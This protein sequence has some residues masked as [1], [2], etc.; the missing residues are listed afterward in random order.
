MKAGFIFF[1][2]MLIMLVPSQ[3]QNITAAKPAYLEVFAQRAD[4]TDVLMTSEQLSVN[5]DNLVMK[6]DLELHTCRTDDMLLRNLL[7]S[8]MNDRL[9]F[10]AVIP[11]GKFAFSSTDNERFSVETDLLYGERQSHILLEF[12]VSNQKTSSAN[13]FMISV[14]GSVLLRED[15]G[16]EKNT[17]INN[18]LSFRF[19][20]NVSKRTF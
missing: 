19:T 7:D 5:Y 12:D 2:F 15:L 3:S 16:L 4:G 14:T 1:F 18:K 8:A 20:Q 17:G 13:T 10:T 9:S 6:G 11:E